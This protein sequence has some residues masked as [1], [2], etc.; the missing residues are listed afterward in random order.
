MPRKGKRYQPA[1]AHWQKVSFADCINPNQITQIPLVLKI[2]QIMIQQYNLLSNL[3]NIGRKIQV[4]YVFLHP[5]VK[6]HHDIVTFQEIIG[7]HVTH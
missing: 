5:V 3:L 7:V 4:C 1:K 2:S 6:I